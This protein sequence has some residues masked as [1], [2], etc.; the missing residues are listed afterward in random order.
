MAPG[1]QDVTDALGRVRD[2]LKPKKEAERATRD[3]RLGL[4]RIVRV[5]P[6][7]QGWKG[8]HVGG[9]NG[10][11]SI[12]AFLSGLFT[13]AGVGYGRYVSPAF[14]ARHNA[15]TINGSTINPRVYDMEARQVN[16]KYQR[17]VQGWRFTES[18]IPQ[19]L[20]PFE[21]ETATAFRL[22]NRMRVP[23]G[24]VEVG[25][26]GATDATNV[27]RRKAVTVI[28]KIDLD[29]QE[30]L[31]RTI[32]DIAK[33]KA[34]IMRP[35]V[36]CVV[37]STNPSSVI[38]VLREHASRVGAAMS[39][40]WKAEPFLKT[41]TE[42]RW[43]LEDYQKQNL[44][45]AALAFRQLFPYKEINLDKLLEMDPY[46][47][48]R[49][50]YVGISKLTKEHKAPV[51]V[52][53]AHNLLGVQ[54]LARYTDANLRLDHQPI[55]WVMGLSSSKTKPFGQI[56][57]TLIR[58]Q[59]N[60]AFI[61]YDQQPNEPP[62]TPADI[63]REIVKRL[64]ETPDQLYTGGTNIMD[65]LQWAG[66]RAGSGRI[67]VTGSLYLVR[68]F[69]K[70]EEVERFREQKSQAPGSSQL[71]RLSKIWRQ[72]PLTEEEHLSFQRAEKQWRQSG[73][74]KGIDDGQDSGVAEDKPVDE[75]V[76]AE[77]ET[78]GG[79]G[80]SVLDSATKT[81][82]DPPRARFDEVVELRRKALRHKQQLEG[83]QIALQSIEDD[84]D[85]QTKNDGIASEALSAL[86]RDA[87]LMQMQAD[88]HEK[89]YKQ[90]MKE[91][92][93][94]PDAGQQYSLTHAEIFG[95]PSYRRP[96]PF[97]QRTELDAPESVETAEPDD[98]LPEEPE[99]NVKRDFWGRPAGIDQIPEPDPSAPKR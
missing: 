1:A 49:M 16:M 43:K 82:K 71:W 50:E 27:M 33:V 9:T 26:G 78:T 68:D 48:G 69:Y 63:G 61:E 97:M 14:P 35:G 91:L 23:Y 81:D 15:V 85:Q 99:D 76:T 5:V 31:G 44:L 66:S 87:D 89:E 39:L 13:L 20:S 37:D 59:D 8:V 80:V 75:G 67:I 12:C 4:E 84:F 60:V 32:E 88:R 45:C 22:F 64:L 21:L 24:I 34:G 62:A 2:V 92:R 29:H 40:S 94:H 30:Y 18:E 72:R 54:S 98:E 46:L 28:S 57:E 56:L 7:A 36:P 83:Y 93:N 90:A 53:A 38:R 77:S 17:I 65:A 55:T 11:G 58:P 3:I 86:R 47:P 95:R 25:M 70:I 96:T 52:D 74:A 10:K 51:L 79:T 73:H 19:P 41:L 6:A 42:E